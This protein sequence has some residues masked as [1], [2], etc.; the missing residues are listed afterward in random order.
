MGETKKQKLIE[1]AFPE[2]FDLTQGHGVVRTRPDMLDPVLN[3]FFFE[4]GGTPPVGI[5]ASVVGEHLLG[6]A[7]FAHSTTVGLDDIL[8]GLTAVESQAGYVATE[9]I[10]I[11]DQIGILPGQ[12]K[13][14]NV[15]LPH[16]VRSGPFEETRSGRIF[17][18]FLFYRGVQPL[19]DQ[20]PLNG[21]GAGADQ[22]KPFQDI[23]D[24]TNPIARIFPFQINDVLSDGGR[25]L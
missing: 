5:L 25:Q 8:G 9:V 18:G 14:Q 20:R 16:L 21:R 6:H 7:V 17:S 15:A 1:D 11:T 4:P 23:G 10:N 19:I 24:T 22:E 3:Q 2:S 12:T 13:R